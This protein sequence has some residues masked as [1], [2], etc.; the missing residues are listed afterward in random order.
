VRLLSVVVPVYNEEH[1]VDRLLRAVLWLLASS[2]LVVVVAAFV[3][4]YNPE[5]WPP[6]WAVFLFATAFAP[7]LLT[8]PRRSMAWSRVL[9]SPTATAS[10]LLGYLALS[11]WTFTG[12]DDW[13]GPRTAVLADATFAPTLAG[14]NINVALY[15][16]GDPMLQPGGLYVDTG[17]ARLLNSVYANG[18]LWAGHTIRSNWGEP[19]DRTN[20]Q[21]YQLDTYS[22]GTVDFQGSF[23]LSGHYYS[24]PAVDFDN[25]YNGVVCFARGGPTEFPGTRYVGL[26]QGGPFDS[27]ALLVAGQTD[28]TGGTAPGTFADPKRWGDYYG[29]A[30]DPYDFK[31]L[32]FYGQFASNSP[33]G[34]WDTVIGAGAPAGNGVL[35][36]TPT[37]TFVSTG[38]QG[39]PFTPPSRV[40]SVSNTGG[41]GIPWTL[42]GLQSWQSA[43]LS[44]GKLQPGGATNV[45]VSINANANLLAPS[46]YIDTYSFTNCYTSGGT[47]NRTTELTVGVDE[48]CPGSV[49]HMRPPGIPP[50]VTSTTTSA[51]QRGIYITALQDFEVCALG[52]EGDFT[53]PQTIT[54]RIYEASGVTRGALIA[55][56]SLTAVQAGKLTH[57]VAI[58]A[59][60]E[61]CKEYDVSVEIGGV[62][63]TWDWWDENL[64]YEPFDVGPIRVRDGESYGGAGTFALPPLSIIGH[65]PAPA[66]VA[67]LGPDA[68]PPSTSTNQNQERGIYV[69]ANETVRMAS[70]GWY[71]N[72]PAG[73]TLTARVYAATGTARGAVIAEGTF[74]TTG[75]GYKW[76]DIPVHATLSEGDD[77]D[78][79]IQF[80]STTQ[81]RW[82]CDADY[83]MPYTAGPL[84]VVTAEFG[85]NPGNCA[86]MQYRMGWDTAGGP[87][88][89]AKQNDVLPPPNSTSQ[90]NSNYGAYVTSLIDQELYSLGWMA[91]IPLGTTLTAR[92]Y[93]AT[94]TTRGALVA[95]GSITSTGDGMRWHDVPLEISLTAGQDYDFTFIWGTVNEWRWWDDRVAP[96]PYDAYGVMRVRD[97]EA[98]GGA[99]T[100]A[101]IH[102]RYNGCDA[103]LTPVAD[104]SPQRVPM[105]LATPAPNPVSGTANIAFAL[106]E[107]GPVTIHIYDV[108]GRK[109]A[110]V[111]ENAG[112]AAGW[113]Q[114]TLDSSRLPSG[115][116]FLKMSTPV[117]SMSRKFVV[118]H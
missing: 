63:N 109:V 48:S 23:G 51:Q 24:Y 10:A 83:T 41:A 95:S 103:T 104:D 16:D 31:T 15:D 65:T 97:S 38:L 14:S 92:I 54:A 9:R 88:D 106:E 117:Q 1:T 87:F 96:M 64:G 42:S 50:D 34:T 29:C 35:S 86:I 116:Y 89:L 18:H 72:L 27:S 4:L 108:A 12:L 101:L 79:A 105:F 52:F 44:S 74:V 20:I 30:R 57:Y 71:A 19:T 32:W 3:W 66:M 26:P 25:N 70:F 5:V 110:T 7:L 36:V 77:Y 43:S 75:T 98:A 67:D 46:T 37:T 90:D 49:V 62:S 114:A 60:L 107:A 21:V 102:M 115:V 99:S 93:E 40:Y 58:N 84:Q 61:A 8:L 13:D 68:L 118:T 33:A 59:T 85:S 39:G 22:V 53:L 94:G 111:L 28:Y 100:Y 81:W 69:T 2:G 56:G 45:T 73:Q 80:G 11:A 6:I 82:W 17:G 78:L 55:T 113:N 91:D 112:R 47:L 76:H